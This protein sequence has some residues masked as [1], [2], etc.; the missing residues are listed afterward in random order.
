MAYY[1]SNQNVKA[2]FKTAIIVRNDMK[3][4]AEN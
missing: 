4:T 3:T 1:F 2:L